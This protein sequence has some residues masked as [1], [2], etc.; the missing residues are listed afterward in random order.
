MRDIQNAF[1]L[2]L[3]ANASV[4]IGATFHSLAAYAPTPLMVALYAEALP[5]YLVGIGFMYDAVQ[6]LISG[7]RKP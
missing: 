1:V 6:S 2:W 5:F 3:L 4:L 7:W